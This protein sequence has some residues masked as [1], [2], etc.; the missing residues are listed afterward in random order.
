MST[1]IGFMAGF[2]CGGIFGFLIAAVLVVGGK[3]K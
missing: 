3:D 2:V 1:V